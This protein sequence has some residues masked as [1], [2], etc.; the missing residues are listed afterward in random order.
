MTEDRALALLRAAERL[1]LVAFEWLPYSD[2]VPDDVKGRVKAASLAISRDLQ[3]VRTGLKEVTE[4]I[5]N[6]AEHR[7]SK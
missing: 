1:G 4:S 2:E 6:V 5:L 3:I 7:G